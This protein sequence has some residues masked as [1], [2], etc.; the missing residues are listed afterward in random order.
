MS[1]VTGVLVVLGALAVLAAPGLL[2][3]KEAYRLRQRET[4][5]DALKVLI[6]LGEQRPANMADILAGRLHLSRRAA[7]RLIQLLSERGLLRVEDDHVRLT[8]LGRALGLHVVRAHRLWECYLSD[9]AAVPLKDVHRLAEK[10]EHHLSPHDV[11]RLEARMGYPRYDP[12]G[13]PIPREG[14][15]EVDRP[16]TP[17]TAWP[18]GTPARIVHVEDEPES[19]FAQVLAEGLTPGTQ[20]IVVER[21]PQGLHLQA[22]GNDIWLATV[23]ASHVHVAPVPQDLPQTTGNMTLAEVPEGMPVKV[24]GLSPE[25]RGLLR[26]RLLDLGFTRGAVVE[27]VLRSSFGRGDPTAYRVR[28]TLIALRREQAQH[29]FVEPVN[30][31]HQEEHH[32]NADENARA[33]TVNT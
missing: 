24:V 12:H 33:H 4:V 29:I 25:V 1:D 19:L 11:R 31:A 9:D 5:E 16:G 27:P 13:D 21:S 22:D 7:L 23:V 18:V 8:P 15:E 30:Q 14:D 2:R 17:L 32:E 20:V 6:E 26:R 28:G 10:A 3:L